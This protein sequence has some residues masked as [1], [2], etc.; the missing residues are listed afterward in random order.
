M[1]VPFVVRALAAQDAAAARRMGGEAFGVP[2]VA[3]DHRPANPAALPG[4]RPWGGFEGEDL[5]ALTVDREYDSWFGGARIPT[6]GIAGVA[7]APEHRGSGKL[8]PLLSTVLRESRIR[9]AVISTLFP[10]APKIYRASGFEVIA[11]LD[12]VELPTHALAAVSPSDLHTR[13]AQADDIAAVRE[14]YDVWAA[15]Q[16]GPLTRRGVSFPATDEDVV[17]SFTGVT[18]AVDADDRVLGYASWDRGQGYGAGSCLEVRD[19]VSLDA[20]AAR[21]LLRVLGS[22]A[23]VTP[24]ARLRT[25]GD[26]LIRY[27]LPGGEWRVLRSGHY[28]LR[29]LDPARAL[30]LRTWPAHLETDVVFGLTDELFADLEGSWRLRVAEGRATCVR[31]DEEPGPWFSTRG[32]AVSYAGAQSTANLRMAGLL[33]G[34]AR[35]DAEWDT[36]FGGRQVHVRDDF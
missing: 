26:D 3:N 34:D 11:H 33:T 22:F 14:V 20:A 36:L 18:L 12:T 24:T 28:M 30:T 7:V 23:P 25:S 1:A 27:A 31:T 32:L 21:A 13:R 17:A 15:A 8:R 10:T 29:L 16:N 9:G 35:H 6:A 4:M 19:L 2:P 5:A